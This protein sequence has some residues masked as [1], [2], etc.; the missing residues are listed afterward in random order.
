MA[1]LTVAGKDGSNTPSGDT[2][3]VVAAKT[4][5]S[6]G[7]LSTLSSETVTYQG[8]GLVFNN[9]YGSNVSVT[10]RNEIVAAE[11]YLQSLFSNTCTVNCSFDLQSLNPIQRRKPTVVR[12]R[13]L[14]AVCRCPEV[15][16]HNALRL[17]HWQTLLT[18]ATAL[19][20]RCLPAKHKYWVLPVW[21]AARTTASSSTAV[22][23]LLQR[24][25]TTP[26]TP[27]RCW[28]TS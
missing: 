21:A 9:T 7:V 6:S 4:G 14:L 24:C 5:A 18:R 17:R 16:R 11:N 12:I 3:V 28:S 20:S 15:T 1:D 27:W 10:F 2:T 26:A 13:S 22:L 19:C 23:G 25:R 8:S